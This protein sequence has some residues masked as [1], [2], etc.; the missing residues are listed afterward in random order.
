M[1]EN[2]GTNPHLTIMNISMNKNGVYTCYALNTAGISV[3][4]SNANSQ[5]TLTVTEG[6]Y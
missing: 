4:A 1:I 3:S 5:H 6:Y 2:S